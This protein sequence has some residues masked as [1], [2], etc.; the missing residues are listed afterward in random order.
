MTTESNKALVRQYLTEVWDKNNLAAIDSFIAPDYI[1]HT[2]SVPPGRP[3]VKLFF[4]LVRTAFSDL[5]YTAE[6]MIAEDDKVAW[7]W[8]IR[9]THS[10]PFQ[11]IPPTGKHITITGMSIVR[12][13]DDQLVEHW[14]E[15]DNLGM[16]QQ[17]GVAPS[18][19]Q[20][21]G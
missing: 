7:R 20:A 12:I 11:Q 18:P 16:L 19:G 4:G 13:A 9:G 8:M 14:G 15:Q 10:G 5:R 6:D 3:G 17:L 1:Q 21:R 2:R